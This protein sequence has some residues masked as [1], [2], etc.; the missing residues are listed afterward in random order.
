M[1]R[2]NRSTIM[3]TIITVIAKYAIVLPV[4]ISAAWLIMAKPADRGR[5]LVLLVLSGI[6]AAL[7]TKL[8]TILI[9]D[10]RPFIA[11]HV[12]P[13]FQSSTDNG[14]PS[15]HTAFATVFAAAIW[16]FNRRLSIGLYVVAVAIGLSRVI[17]GVHHSWDVIGGLLIG[18]AA[19][20]AVYWCTR[21]FERFRDKEKLTVGKGK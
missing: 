6:L 5:Y 2:D 3:H 18:T 7:L 11:G 1:F 17:A 9:Q 15:D 16:P 8:G 20:A 21:L 13:Y 14:F 12:M 10:P 4:V 19:V